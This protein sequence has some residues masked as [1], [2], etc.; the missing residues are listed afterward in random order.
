MK[1][2]REIHDATSNLR[3]VTAIL[4]SDQQRTLKLL[5]SGSGDLDELKKSLK[6]DQVE[7]ILFRTNAVMYDINTTKFVAI[8]W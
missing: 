1:A 4:G 6:E 8:T 5:N 2:I 3:W 7:F